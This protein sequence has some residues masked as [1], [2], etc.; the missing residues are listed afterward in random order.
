MA[1]I[2]LEAQQAVDKL[3]EEI[4]RVCKEHNVMVLANFAYGVQGD[5]TSMTH[6]CPNKDG[7]IVE[8]QQEALCVLGHYD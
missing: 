3:C 6:V 1:Q 4:D 8:C 5:V 2:N 7:M